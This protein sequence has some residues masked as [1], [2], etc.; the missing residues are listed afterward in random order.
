MGHLPAMLNFNLSRQRTSHDNKIV[1]IAVISVQEIAN[2]GL[3]NI[4]P[5]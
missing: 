4:T 5:P 2:R 3:S 1:P